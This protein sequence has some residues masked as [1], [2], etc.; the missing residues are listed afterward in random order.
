MKYVLC[1]T[2]VTLSTTQS[3]QHYMYEHEV[4]HFIRPQFSQVGQFEITRKSN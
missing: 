1:F 2:D 4:P 3:Q